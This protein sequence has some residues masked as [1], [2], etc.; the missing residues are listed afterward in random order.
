LA[1]IL[2][3]GLQEKEEQAKK[4]KAKPPVRKKS[5]SVGEIGMLSR[6]YTVHYMKFKPPVRKKANSMGEIA[7]LSR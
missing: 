4:V 2:N 1:I 7:M 5:S 6:Y 3:S